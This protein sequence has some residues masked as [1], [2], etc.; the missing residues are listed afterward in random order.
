MNK[1][2]IRELT[3]KFLYSIELL[4]EN[5]DEQLEMYI[6]NNEI[7]NSQAIKY[8]PKI[9]HGIMDK[10]EQIEN[11]ISENLKNGWNINRISKVDLVLLKLAIYEIIY[12]DIPYQVEINEVVELAKKY[13]EESSKSFINGLLASIVKKSGEKQINEV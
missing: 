5:I 2:E 7:D 3:F 12:D 9:T 11:M 8:M 6:K 4:N 13:G 10:K 1:S